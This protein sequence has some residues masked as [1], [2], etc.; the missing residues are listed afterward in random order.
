MFHDSLSNDIQVVPRGQTD[1][2]KKIF[3]FHNSA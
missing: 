1:M 3:A 2:T